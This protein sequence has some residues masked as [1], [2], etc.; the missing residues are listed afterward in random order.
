M[1]IKTTSVWPVN[2]L[3]EI[4]VQAGTGTTSVTGFVSQDQIATDDSSNKV[5]MKLPDLTAITLAEVLT[6]FV[7]GA[8]SV[9]ASDTVLQ[10]FNKL[11]GN[12]NLKALNLLTGY[13]SGAGTVAATDTVLQGI[14]K[15]NGNVAAKAN[16]ASPSFTGNTTT[17]AVTYNTRVHIAAGAVTVA[18]TDHIIVVNKTVGASTNVPLPVGVLGRCLIIKD[19]KGDASSNNITLTPNSGNIDGA[20]TFV[21]NADRQAMTIVFSGGE[22]SII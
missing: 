5:V 12:T 16:T 4:V 13:V 2:E 17:Q 1:T 21:M 6:G 8:G 19:G 14:N 9:S 11:D 15:L 20:A 22:W 10:A 7:S 18:A 3:N